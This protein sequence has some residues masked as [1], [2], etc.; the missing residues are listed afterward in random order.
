MDIAG[1]TA[2]HGALV[3]ELHQVAAIASILL[4]TLG[5]AIVALALFDR[6]GTRGPLGQAVVTFGACHCFLHFA[7]VRD[8]LTGRSRGP[9]AGVS[10]R[11]ALRRHF[12][13]RP[14]PGVAARLAVRFTRSGRWCSPSLRTLPLV[15]C[16][17]R[18]PSR[19]MAF[20]L[21]APRNPDSSSRTAST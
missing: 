16:G 12:P 5:P 2:A 11:L 18:A 4:M 14:A 13:E 6:I 9:R 20:V 3:P 1:D 21:V 7:V 10:R 8:P 17:E 15:R 19:G